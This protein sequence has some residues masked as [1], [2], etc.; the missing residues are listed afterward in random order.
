MEFNGY[1]PG[2]I[3]VLKSAP[4]YKIGYADDV[5]QRLKTISAAARPDDMIEPITLLFSFQTTS[6]MVAERTLHDYFKRY[7]VKGE[8][9]KLTDQHLAILQRF[10]DVSVDEFVIQL[11]GLPNDLLLYTREDIEFAKTYQLRFV[12]DKELVPADELEGHIEQERARRGRQHRIE[13]YRKVLGNLLEHMSMEDMEWL[14]RTAMR[15]GV[16]DEPSESD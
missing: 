1:K 5:E 9:F 8:W 10:T 2:Y 7:R 4:Y 14:Y 11:H 15:R 16:T 13:R 3:Y 6:K 12:G